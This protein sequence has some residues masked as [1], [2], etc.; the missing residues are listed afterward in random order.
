MFPTQ[1]PAF[2]KG[3]S[4]LSSAFSDFDSP[5][6]KPPVPT[7]GPPSLL[8]GNKG[9]PIILLILEYKT[10]WFLLMLWVLSEKTDADLFPTPVDLPQKISSPA[11]NHQ[12]S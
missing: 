12:K 2:P 7:C 5:H 10:K 1:N 4:R 6:P 11:E 9:F 8:G 3:P